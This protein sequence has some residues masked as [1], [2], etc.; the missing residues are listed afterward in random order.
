[1]IERIARVGRLGLVATEAEKLPYSIELW[2]SGGHALERV[3]ARALDAQLARAIFHAA[4]KEHPEAR[5]LLRRGT[6]TVADSA[7]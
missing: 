3:L 4:Q 7:D 2:D 6:R 5:I 1:M